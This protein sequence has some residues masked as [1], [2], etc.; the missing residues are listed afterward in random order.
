MN[1]S[2]TYEINLTEAEQEALKLDFDNRL[3]KAPTKESDIVDQLGALRMILSDKL[4]DIDRTLEN[5]IKELIETLYM[6]L[7]PLE[8]IKGELLELR[9]N[10]KNQGEALERQ[11]DRII[12]MQENAFD[13]D[14]E[15]V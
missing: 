6:T 13:C 14:E 12:A 15:I 4:G 5:G 8:D 10:I 2:T 7:T 9:Y 11:N 1:R 3:P